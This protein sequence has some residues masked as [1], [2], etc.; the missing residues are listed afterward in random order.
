MALSS[1][2]R[3]ALF[4][5][6]AMS[7][8]TINDAIA[9]HVA[10]VMN[11]G[12]LIFVR[13]AFATVMIGTL[14]WA[15]GAFRGGAWYSHPM[16]WLRAAGD[17]AASVT[18]LLALSRMPLANVSA[19]LQSLPLAVTM[20]AALFLGEPVG[21][22]R[23]IAIVVGFA[24]VMIVV[25]PG[26]EG[27]DAYA[28]YAL[29]CVLFCVV[30]DLATR[31]LPPHIPSLLVATVTAGCIGAFGGLMTVPLGGWT[32]MDWRTTGELAIAAV[33]LIT[34]YQFIIKAMREGDIS[35]VAPFRYTALV[36]AITLG[37]VMFGD[38]PD[39]A[40]ILGSA[41]VIASGIYTLYRERKRGA[42][43]PAAETTVVA[44]T[45]DGN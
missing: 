34:G 31:R 28:I 15:S 19:V 42:T 10:D 41:L 18:F 38:I 24:G 35:F 36:W 25:R 44:M 11:I 1:N 39:L 21:W 33:L 2:M 23:W 14:A 40:M 4:M 16:V 13:G 27:F 3:G 26:F 9:K 43:R 32:P 37:M 7:A 5:T 45:P 8:F 17:L 12:Q 29:L 6:L 20:G 30:R 22:R